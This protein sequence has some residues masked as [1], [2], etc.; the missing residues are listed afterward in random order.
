MW[1]MQVSVCCQWQIIHM[2]CMLYLCS[3][4][5]LNECT[6]GLDIFLEVKLDNVN[7]AQQ[8]KEK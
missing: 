1:L 8:Q 2:W 4:H 6:V 7:L 5:L 3:S